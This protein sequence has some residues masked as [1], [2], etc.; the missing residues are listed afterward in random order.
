V[1][2]DPEVNVRL[3]LKDKLSAG[4]KKTSS[5]VKK[6]STRFKQLATSARAAA[7]AMSG[8]F[9]AGLALAAL[10]LRSLARVLGEAVE[11]SAEQEA[12]VKALTDAL[13]PLGSKAETVSQ[14][15]QEQ[16]AAL[17]KVSTFG[18]ETIIRAQALIAAFVRDEDQ[19]KAATKAT[20][21]LAAAKGFDLVTAA[22]LVSKTLGSSTNALKR[23][24]IEA[25]GAVGSTERL[26]SLTGNIEKV[27]GGRAA[28]EI[29]TYAGAIKQLSN[30]YGDFLEVLGNTVTKS[31]AVRETIDRLLGFFT[32]PA[33]T[34]GIRDFSNL[35]FSV[36]NHLATAAGIVKKIVL[37]PF[38][39]MATLLTSWVPLALA[40]GESIR[41]LTDDSVDYAAQA[42]RM[43]ITEAEL[44]RI[45]TARIAANREASISTT[46]FAA[47]QAK[48]AEAAEEL[49]KSEAIA[50]KAA[51]ELA[52]AQKDAAIA[53]EIQKTE[54]NKLKKSVEDTANAYDGALA[55]ASRFGS[56]SSAILEGEI[57]GIETALLD[58][59][60]IH[61]EYSLE[62]QR[63]VEDAA[64]ATE[65]LQRRIDSLKSGHGDL[66]TATQETIR[67]NVEL[68]QSTE[69]AALGLGRQALAA[70]A[71]TN[72]QLGLNSASNAY[73]QLNATASQIGQPS[74]FAS[75]GRGTFTFP[76]GTVVVD[77]TGRRITV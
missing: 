2:R 6:A 73:R 40:A 77:G 28:G 5:G 21:D 26:S 14:A 12:A 75:I 29:D 65:R 15:L 39:S 13:A 45:V 16:A 63:Q 72:A 37:P 35:I 56:V 24:G 9:L 31:G 20:L 58:L 17:Q 10:A 46:E 38:Q 36:V 22:D 52:Q 19:I 27:F 67:E 50:V 68:A 33:T 44:Q 1:A 43:G 41:Q 57:I 53:A 62:Y 34:K 3:G 49:A 64:R 74:S 48:A 51:E 61:G 11:K 59:K 4:L 25:K 54:L 66:K 70:N 30:A 42:E 55:S 60:N 76:A 7:A 32:D 69:T 8:P 23:Y 18:D 47:E 71:A